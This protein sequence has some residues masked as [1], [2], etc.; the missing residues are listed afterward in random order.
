M[1]KDKSNHK[2]SPKLYK[3]MKSLNPKGRPKGSVN[4]YTQLARELLSSRGEEIVEVVIAKALKGDVH[5]LK[6]C[7]DRIVPAQKAV[8]IK[9]TKSEDGLIINVGTSAQIEEMAKVNKPKRLK[10]K[11]D[12]EVIATIV[13]EEEK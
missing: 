11:G 8:E 9:H 10:T 4:K 6:M 7:M 3:G 2:G 1:S 13:K 12:D 5:C